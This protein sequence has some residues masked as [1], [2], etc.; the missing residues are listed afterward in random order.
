MHRVCGLG[1]TI[2]T[3]TKYHVCNTRNKHLYT[4]YVTSMHHN[5]VVL[6]LFSTD[7]SENVTFNIQW[8]QQKRFD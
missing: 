8:E 6:T 2:N 4:T 5:S 7:V 1:S 3:L